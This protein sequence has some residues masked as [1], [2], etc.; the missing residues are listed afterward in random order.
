MSSM[1]D[2]DADR[3]EDRRQRAK[4]DQDA[5]ESEWGPGMG[6][7]APPPPP[8]SRPMPL[9]E[10]VWPAAF[11]TQQS[12]STRPADG[13]G[14]QEMATSYEEEAADDDEVMLRANKAVLLQIYNQVLASSSYYK[15]KI[16][17]LWKRAIW[18]MV[19][20]MIECEQHAW[21]LEYFVFYRSIS[22]KYVLY[23]F[24]TLMLL[25]FSEVP[26]PELAQR[27]ICVP[28]LDEADFCPSIES[29]IQLFGERGM[30][31]SAP[32]VANAIIPVNNCLF[33]TKSG[34]VVYH[35]QHSAE[36]APLSNLFTGYNATIAYESKITS[37]L[38][39]LL[40]M[41]TEEAERVLTEML[42]LYRAQF[43]ALPM[44]ADVADA[45]TLQIC[46]PRSQ[47]ERFAYPCVAWGYPVRLFLSR[48]ERIH[49][50]PVFE[51]NRYEGYG[52]E[53][54]SAMEAPLSLTEFLRMPEMSD[55]QTRI[56]AHPNLFLRHGAV[57]NVF[58]TDPHFDPARF[59]AQMI[60][61]LR[62]WIE[63]AMGDGQ[64]V[65]PKLSYSLYQ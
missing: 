21:R 3:V 23:E 56:L 1:W 51:H 19:S 9:A 35:V 61:L 59:R 17:A 6:L 42:A 58:H 40:E 24:H 50:F 28:S 27:L 7:T 44:G 26:V 32:R 63:R 53:P 12:M 52:S 4:R 20:N 49:A 43:Q 8:A 34:R 31:D 18:N 57:T 33:P 47:L 45:H 54:E 46:I 11:Q 65:R 37:T 38:R 48:T 22:K 5:F 55:L 60:E 15:H 36:A 10:L 13:R 25:F 29:E 62:S 39:T 64:A 14:R 30:N 16:D 2:S 41:S